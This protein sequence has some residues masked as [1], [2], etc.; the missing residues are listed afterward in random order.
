MLIII[1]YIAVV[2]CVFGG[3]LMVGGHLGALWQPAEIVII[4]GAGM[5]AFIASNSGHGIKATIRILPKLMKSSHYNKEMFLDLM[6]LLY[7]ILAKGRQ[8]GMMALEKDIDSPEDSP[9][10]SQYPA[11]VNDPL[12]MEF[13]TDYLRL[14]ISG[15]MDPFEIESLMDHEIETFQHEAEVPAHS[16]NAVGDGLPAFGIVAAVMG[17]VHTLGAEGLE[18]EQIGP[19]IANAMVGTFLG[20]LLAYGFVTPLANKVKHHVEEMVKMLQC[21]KVTL[22]ANLNGYA[23]P[24]AV[25]FGRKALFASERPSFSELEEHVRSVKSKPAG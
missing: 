11:L 8:E 1:G 12:L 14:M 3:Y 24:L 18:P 5:G 9:I 10:F 21:I 23:P 17:V 20:I 6:G 4:F 22:L 25:E 16:I 7:L 2:A 13:L 15:N 19:L